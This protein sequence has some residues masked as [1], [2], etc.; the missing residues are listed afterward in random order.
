MEE[1]KKETIFYAHH[2]VK[3]GMPKALPDTLMPDK[4]HLPAN[5]PSL[6]FLMTLCPAF[7]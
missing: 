2:L 7:A 5:Y 3:L 6:C 1:Y 4:P